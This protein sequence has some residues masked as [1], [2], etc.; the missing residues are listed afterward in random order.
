MVGPS[1]K[2]ILFSL[3]GNEKRKQSKGSG[4]KQGEINLTLKIGH[5]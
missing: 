3:S 2:N 4:G 1:R 5:F